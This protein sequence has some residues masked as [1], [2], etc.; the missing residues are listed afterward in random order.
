M[1]KK[2]NAVPE[3]SS[4]SGLL[5]TEE[6]SIRTRFKENTIRLWVARGLIPHYRFGRQ[7]RIRSVDLEKF[8]ND[9]FVP[10]KGPD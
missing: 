10:S 3:T 4:D 6:V 2:K 9:N 1:K 5:T 8:L 7:I